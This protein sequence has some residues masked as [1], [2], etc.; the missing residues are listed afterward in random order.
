MTSPKIIISKDKKKLNVDLICSFL[1][2][3]YWA[4]NRTKEEI[5]KSIKNAICFGV[6]EE[7]LQV[8]FA[9][10]ITDQITFAYIADVFIISP[11][12]GLGYSK[13]L[14]SSIVHDNVLSEVRKWYLVTKDA[15]GLYEKY[16]FKNFNDKE[17]TVMKMSNL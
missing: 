16:G 12:R 10:V 5:E 14:M 6:Y 11:K 7:D 15:Q 3:S 9:R 13:K 8:G 17:M 4:K 1:Q 2:Q